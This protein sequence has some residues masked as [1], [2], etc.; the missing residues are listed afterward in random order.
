MRFGPDQKADL[1]RIFPLQ[2][3]SSIYGPLQITEAGFRITGLK[4]PESSFADL[5]WYITAK[6]VASQKTLQIMVKP[7]HGRIIAISE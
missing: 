2:G 4:E 1:L 6:R 3:L 7:F 5:H